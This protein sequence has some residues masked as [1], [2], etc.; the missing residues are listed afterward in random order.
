[1]NVEPTERM[2]E[3]ARASAILFQWEL[4]SAQADNSEQSL[5]HIERGSGVAANLRGTLKNLGAPLKVIHSLAADLLW[6]T[7]KLNPAWPSAAQ[8]EKQEQEKGT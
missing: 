2:Q 3:Y 6:H 5:R 8:A 4:A 7:Q 1:M